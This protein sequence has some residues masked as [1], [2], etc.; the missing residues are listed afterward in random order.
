MH[1][2]K[3]NKTINIKRLLTNVPEEDKLPKELHE[4]SQLYFRLL[5]KMHRIGLA[6]EQDKDSIK[7]PFK[8]SDGDSK[9]LQYTFFTNA[10]VSFI[11]TLKTFEHLQEMH[12]SQPP[13]EQ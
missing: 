13:E 12:A 11:R 1:K 9:E 8:S 4:L 2:T 3:P 10:C 5:N 6:N 7:P